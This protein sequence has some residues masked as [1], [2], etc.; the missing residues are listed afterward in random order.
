ME[1]SIAELKV[2]KLFRILLHTQTCSHTN[3]LYS[4]AYDHVI[5]L[6]TSEA[7][8]NLQVVRI[9]Y[10]KNSPSSSPVTAMTHLHGGYP[11]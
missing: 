11:D 4:L 1:V 2:H 8:G 5:L 3:I 6:I 9:G 10:T 7:F